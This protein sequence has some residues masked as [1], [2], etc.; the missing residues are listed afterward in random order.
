MTQAALAVVAALADGPD[1]PSAVQWQPGTQTLTWT[2]SN[3]AAGY[4]VALRRTESVAFDKAI[5]IAPHTM[6][7]WPGLS[8]YDFA[9]IAA[10]DQRG[11]IGPFST[12][13]ALR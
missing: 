11:R 2:A 6:F 9:A 12:E 7:D 1:P 10:Y 13:I 4:V 3:Q 8:A 5:T